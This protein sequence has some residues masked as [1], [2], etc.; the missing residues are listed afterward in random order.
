MSKQ[1]QDSK[2]D[3]IEQLLQLCRQNPTLLQETSELARILS[4]VRLIQ[5]Q[6][7]SCLDPEWVRKYGSDCHNCGEEGHYTYWCRFAHSVKWKKTQSEPKCVEKLKADDPKYEFDWNGECMIY[8]LLRDPKYQERINRKMDPLW[9]NQKIEYYIPTDLFEKHAAIFIQVKTS[10]NATGP[11]KIYVS[12]NERDLM[13]TAPNNYELYVVNTSQKYIVRITN[14][15]KL[16]SGPKFDCNDPISIRPTGTCMG[17][18]NTF[19]YFEASTVDAF[20]Y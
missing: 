13:R 5:E 16:S 6:R 3:L 9:L 8:Q 18:F 12:P 7:E 20:S 11:S 10:S 17:W 14:I 1:T 2:S 19:E 4:S 15:A